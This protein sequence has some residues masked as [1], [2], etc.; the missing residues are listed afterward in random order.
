MKLGLKAVTSRLFVLL[1][2]SRVDVEEKNA[3]DGM[4]NKQNIG[5]GTR[6]PGFSRPKLGW[7]I[8]IYFC[9]VQ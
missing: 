9:S 3:S 1:T 7:N 6:V 8:M 2:Q 4:I 5:S